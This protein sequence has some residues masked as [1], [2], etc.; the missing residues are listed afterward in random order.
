[1]KRLNIFGWV[2][3]LAVVV[4]CR[5]KF[6]PDLESTT[7]SHLVVDGVLNTGTGGTTIQLSR[8]TTLD[9]RVQF[10]PE[11]NAIVTVE[12]E[13]NSVQPLFWNGNGLYAS[14]GLNLTINNNYRLR[15]KTIDG[16]EYLSEYVKARH[17]PAIDSVGYH[18]KEHGIQL[19][20]NAKDPSNSTW[21]YRYEFDETWE[22]HSYYF[23]R[24]IYIK[25]TNSVR[26]R[27]PGEEVYQCWKYG[28]S[29]GIAL[30]SSVRL[31]EDVIHEAPIH[32]IGKNSEKMSVRYSILVK[33]YAID[34]PGYQFYEQMKQNTE[35][36]G[37]VFD[38][39]PSQVWGNVKC[40]TNPSE[41]VIGYVSACEIREKRFFIS[42]QEL[43]D[44]RFYQ[45]CPSKNIANQPDSLR[46][47]SYDVYQ[48]YSALISTTTGAITH[49][50][51]AAKECVDCTE[52]GGSLIRP[53]Y[54]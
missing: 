12:G 18:K 38:P 1:M 14:G 22:I 16:R 9:S 4:S 21:Y 34:K 30:A 11:P 52:R 13:D 54:W 45:D 25:Q 19:Y 32:F 8:T 29:T 44:W 36:M 37:T 7:A 46:E 49:Y 39:Q 50:V 15:I 27:L 10:V 47:F 17:T 42:A 23:S 26:D 40:I 20:V 35:N 33:Q 3:L 6:E 43:D 5:D 28:S 24:Y 51:S 53:S 2:L 48:P 41:L 31:Q